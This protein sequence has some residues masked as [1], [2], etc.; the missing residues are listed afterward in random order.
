[1]LYVP[2]VIVIDFTMPSYLAQESQGS[3][4]VCVAV[5]G[6]I[7]REVVVELTTSEDSAL[8]CKYNF[9]SR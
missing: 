9:G 4:T 1:M 7:N 2:A 5:V 3:V 6:G 8:D